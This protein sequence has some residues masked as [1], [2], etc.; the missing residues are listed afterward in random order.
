MPDMGITVQLLGCA[1]PIHSNLQ[2]KRNGRTPPVS[3]L[4][5]MG[6]R[7]LLWVP[8]LAAGFACFPASV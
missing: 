7:L 6:L 4:A 3:V 2:E 8:E 1:A 5:E